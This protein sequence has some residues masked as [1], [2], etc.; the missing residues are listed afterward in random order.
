MKHILEMGGKKLEIYFNK[1]IY[2]PEYSSEGC[3]ALVGKLISDG[4][5]DNLSIIDV[6]CGSGFTGL[7]IKKLNPFFPEGE[8][9][10]K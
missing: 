7:G 8:F 10:N 9:C 6:G 4:G 2:S 1:K 5:K 3:I